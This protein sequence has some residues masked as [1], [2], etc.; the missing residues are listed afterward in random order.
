LHAR[1]TT[2]EMDPARIDEVVAQVE[3]QDLPT[4]KGIDGFKGFTL[5]IDRSSGKVIGTSYWSTQEQ[6][7]AS[8]EKVVE[9]RQRAADAGGASSPPQVERFEVGLDSFMK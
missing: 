5:L 6:M 2:I 8:E 9:S 4:W 1:V 3:E 7:Q